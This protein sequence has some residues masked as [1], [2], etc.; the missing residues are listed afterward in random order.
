MTET[1]KLAADIF[2]LA[3]SKAE[4]LGSM[5]KN[6]RRILFKEAAEL[7]FEAASAFMEVKHE[8]SC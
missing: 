2:A 4:E 6:D 3:L 7:C 5:T 8:K 1:E